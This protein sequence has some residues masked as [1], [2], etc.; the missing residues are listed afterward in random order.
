MESSRATTGEAQPQRLR[1]CTTVNYFT[2]ADRVYVRGAR[3][4]RDGYL[5]PTKRKI[6][7]N[8]GACTGVSPGI[9]EECSPRVITPLV[10][11]A[12]P[13]RLRE[14]ML[15]RLDRCGDRLRVDSC[16]GYPPGERTMLR[17]A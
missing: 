2:G 6:Q 15:Q 16:S 3:V 4:P 7:K 13:R 8:T 1:L 10:P 14:E 9:K 11:S 17:A 12:F 5:Q